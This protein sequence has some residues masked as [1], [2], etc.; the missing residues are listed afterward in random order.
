MRVLA[1]WITSATLFSVLLAGTT[2]TRGDEA[3]GVTGV[4]SLFGS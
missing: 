2:S 4:K 1:C 3:S